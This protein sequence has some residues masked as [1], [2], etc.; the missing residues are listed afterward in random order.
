M[1]NP[2]EH[3]NSFLEKCDTKKI[4]GTSEEAL[5]FC[6]FPYY[7]RD[8][9]KEWLKSQDHASK[10]TSWNELAIASCQKYVPPK[11]AA[12]MRMRSHPSLSCMVNHSMKPGKVQGFTKATSSS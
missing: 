10:F 9:E 12:K 6:L 4:N 3:I 8:R 1:E 7:L 2:N 5:R 11:N